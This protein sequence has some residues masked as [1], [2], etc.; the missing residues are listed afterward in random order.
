M[1][2]FRIRAPEAELLELCLFEGERETRLPMR[3]NATN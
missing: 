2:A 3:R 1:T